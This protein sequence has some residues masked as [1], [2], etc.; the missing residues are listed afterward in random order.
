MTT[1]TITAPIQ[2]ETYTVTYRVDAYYTVQVECPCGSTPEEIIENVGREDLAEADE[3]EGVW[4]GLKDAWRNGNVAR[5]ENEA[6][7]DLI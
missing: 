7:D 2:T 3:C 4:D 5:V 1:T 6:G